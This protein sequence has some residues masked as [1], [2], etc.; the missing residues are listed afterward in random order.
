MSFEESARKVFRNSQRSSPTGGILK[1]EAVYRFAKVLAERSVQ[2]LQDAH[3][4]LE[5]RSE[6]EERIRQ[7][8][9]QKSGISFDY[10]LMLIGSEDTVKP[11]RMLCRFLRETLGRDV[12]QSECLSL[13][14]GAARELRGRYPQM[15][16]RLLDYAI[17]N[18]QRQRPSSK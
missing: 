14:A 4:I 7:I 12:G 10:F 3:V 13:V 2:H 1:S 17:W 15:T 9:G 16:A 8:P 6:F 11:D 18:Y 5:Q